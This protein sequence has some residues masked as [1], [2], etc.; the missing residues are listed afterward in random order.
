MTMSR[1]IWIAGGAGALLGLI[2]VA[3]IARADMGWRPEMWRHGSGPGPGVRMMLERY[4]ANK[5]GA[6]SQDEI[7]SNRAA[8]LAEFD[9]DKSGDLSISEFQAL[10]LKARHEQMVREFQQFD[11]DGDGKVTLEEYKGPLEHFIA[12]LDMNGDG[13]VNKEDMKLRH[14]QGMGHDGDH[15]DGKPGQMDQDND[16]PGSSDGGDQ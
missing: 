10:W 13:V 15:G 16:Q 14:R 2:A 4:D 1:K 8:W 12:E 11:R 7:D 3:G 9:T 6:L 5:D